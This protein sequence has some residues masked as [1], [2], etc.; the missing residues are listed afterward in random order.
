MRY[1]RRGDFSQAIIYF[2]K[3]G[4]INDSKDRLAFSKTMQEAQGEW[5]W[6]N[7]RGAHPEIGMRGRDHK[8][9][10]S[11]WSVIRLDWHPD[12][13]NEIR[14]F[15]FKVNRDEITDNK[16]TAEYVSIYGA[17]W[18]F[19]YDSKEGM[20]IQYDSSYVKDKRFIRPRTHDF[21]YIPDIGMTGKDV[22][23]SLW[24]EPNN[25]SRSKSASGETQRWEYKFLN[26]D[27]IVLYLVNDVVTEIFYH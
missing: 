2:E 13:P 11:G 16:L 23:N 9:I 19:V 8:I 14:E 10:V 24:G 6:N 22:L 17:I 3:A 12:S 21:F 7:G 4:D 15:V 5:V 25:I 26:S 18:H 27:P 1:Y 20:Q